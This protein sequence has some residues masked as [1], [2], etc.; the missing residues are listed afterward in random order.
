MSYQLTESSP[1]QYFWSEGEP[2]AQWMQVR[3]DVVA[4]RAERPAYFLRKEFVVSGPVKKATIKATAQGI[5]N[6]Y[7][8]GNRIGDKVLTPDTT[9]YRFHIAVQEYDV[10]HAIKPGTHTVVFELADGFFRSSTGVWRVDV[11]Y[12]NHV[13]ALFEMDI[14]YTDGT[15]QS[16]DSDLTWKVSPS[17]ILAADLMEGQVEDRRLFDSAIK[18]NGFDDSAWDAPILGSTEAALV[19]EFAPPIRAIEELKPVSIKT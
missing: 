19:R 1:Y 18:M 16:V 2:R 15:H 14:D 17:H 11:N 12:E 13:A 9:D 5:Y 10:T 3:E 6:I 4:E 8:D 7:I